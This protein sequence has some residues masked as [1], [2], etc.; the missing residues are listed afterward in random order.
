MPRIIKCYRSYSKQKMADG[1]PLEHNGAPVMEP[2]VEEHSMLV[3]DAKEAVK[4]GRGEWSLTAPKGTFMPE[5]IVS[6]L[7]PEPPK[8]GR[9]AFGVTA[10]D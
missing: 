5:V 9:K 7:N 8:K 2:V 6:D 1:K 10:D 3:Y 4:N